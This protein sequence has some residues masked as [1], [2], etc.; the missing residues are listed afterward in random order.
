MLIYFSARFFLLF[1]YCFVLVVLSS[2]WSSVRPG[3]RIIHENNKTRS[4]Q[5]YL[6]FLHFLLSISQYVNWHGDYWQIGDWIKF[7]N[8]PLNHTT[9]LHLKLSY[10]TAWVWYFLQTLFNIIINISIEHWCR[11]G[12][13]I[14]RTFTKMQWRHQS[15]FTNG[16]NLWKHHEEIGDDGRRQEHI[17]IQT[18][19]VRQ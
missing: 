7:R 1:K 2:N 16:N 5:I 19:A 8:D 14:A 17:Q 10:G 6:D 9:S 3:Q 4:D 15:N 11:T 13:D 12:G 18:P